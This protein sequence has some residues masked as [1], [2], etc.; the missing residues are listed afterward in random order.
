LYGYEKPEF[1]ATV[2]KDSL[3]EWQDDHA[4]VTLY[5]EI[6]AEVGGWYSFGLAFSPVVMVKLSQPVPLAEFLT[7]WAWPLRGLIAAATGRGADISYLTCSP[8]I[9]GDL[10]SHERR[11]F[12]VFNASITQEPYTSSVD[13]LS[14]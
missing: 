14:G 6:S 5:Y 12:Q 3:Q 9:D 1:A 10:R 8:V 4:E 13:R 2:D 11:Q 7:Q